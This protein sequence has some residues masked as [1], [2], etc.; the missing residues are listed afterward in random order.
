MSSHQGSG[1]LDRDVYL[2]TLLKLLVQLTPAHQQGS[3]AFCRCRYIGML[4]Q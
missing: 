1:P 3:G 4:V 2:H